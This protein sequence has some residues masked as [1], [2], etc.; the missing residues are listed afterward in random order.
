MRAIVVN[1]RRLPLR[2]GEQLEDP[3]DIRTRTAAGEL[4]IAERPRAPFTK[5][6]IAFRIKRTSLVE[7]MDVMNPF[8]HRAA[9]LE[10]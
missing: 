7:S 4:P 10:Y 1:N 2:R 3:T 5:Q 8:A 9:A 6:I